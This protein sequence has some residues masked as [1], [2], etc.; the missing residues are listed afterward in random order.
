[1]KRFLLLAALVAALPASASAACPSAARHGA[2]FHRRAVVVSVP[3]VPAT[4]VPAAPVKPY[5]PTVK[6]QASI[7]SP[8]LFVAAPVILPVPMATPIRSAAAAFVEAA[9]VRTLVTGTANRVRVFGRA[10]VTGG[11]PG[12]VCGR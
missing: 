8:P 9:P 6:P 2:L 12:G 7:P 1:M 4:A 5:Y 10:L 3:V 11:C